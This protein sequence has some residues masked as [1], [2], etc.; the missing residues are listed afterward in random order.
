CNSSL[1][2][3]RLP[4]QALADFR[5]IGPCPKELQGLTWIEELL[6]AR[7]HLVGKVLRLQKRNASSYFALKGHV[8]LLPQDTTRLLDLL[9]MALTSLPDVVHVVWVGSSMP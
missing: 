7:G 1:Q 2:N 4:P 5:W 9:P 8:I 3:G 6:I